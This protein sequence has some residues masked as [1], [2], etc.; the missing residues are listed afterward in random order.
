MKGAKAEYEQIAGLCRVAAEEEKL[1]AAQNLLDDLK[2]TWLDGADRAWLFEH[3]EARCFEWAKCRV[4]RRAC[5]LRYGAAYLIH[6]V[7]GLALHCV[8]GPLTR[9][10]LLRQ[11]TTHTSNNTNGNTQ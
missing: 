4:G 5:P 11:Y 9:F 1:K 2:L 10:Q 3:L 7:S 6:C 8:E